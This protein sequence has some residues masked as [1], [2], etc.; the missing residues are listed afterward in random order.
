M[1]SEVVYEPTFS[2]MSHGFQ[3]RKSC[4]TALKGIR[5]N[6]QATTWAIGGDISNYYDTI[7]LH[8]PT[9]IMRRKIG[10]NKSMR[11]IRRTLRAGKCE[12]NT[13][14]AACRLGPRKWP[15]RQFE[16]PTLFVKKEGVPQGNNISPILASIYYN[17]LDQWMIEKIRRFNRG[18]EGP[19]GQKTLRVFWKRNSKWIKITFRLKYARKKGQAQRIAELES[20]QKQTP[21][22]I[23][24]DKDFRWPK[25][26]RYVDNSI[27]GVTAPLSEAKQPEAE[28]AELPRERPEQEGKTKITHPYSEETLFLG[29]TISLKGTR[30]KQ[31]SEQRIGSVIRKPRIAPVRMKASIDRIITKPYK[32]HM[33]SQGGRK[34][35]SITTL[36]D[37]SHD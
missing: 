28:I 17:E 16:L 37:N 14:K 22:T 20:Q 29:T 30:I 5:T 33:P 25:Y 24:N 27:I 35:K 34:P 3:P 4:H 2:K 12:F 1:I 31:S 19:V 9:G 6:F 18:R 23:M 36:R 11:L 15:E 32:I 7:D 26:V 10:D 13:T 21:A 8:I